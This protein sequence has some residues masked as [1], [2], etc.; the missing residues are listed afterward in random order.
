MKR[1]VVW[2]LK[3]NLFLLIVIVFMLFFYNSSKNLPAD[4]VS[5]PNIIMM[6]MIVLVIWNLAGAIFEYKDFLKENPVPEKVPGPRGVDLLK[7]KVS[8][9]IKGPDKKIDRTNVLLYVVTLLYGII[10]P[11]IGFGIM[12][13]AYLI[14]AAFLLGAKK[15]IGF[16]V[17]VV[18]VFGSIYGVFAVWLGVP[19]PKGLLF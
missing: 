4:A 19:F 6:C 9:F 11:F 18:A 16:V 2:F 12:S 3:N 1:F 14:G 5:Y 17:F 15:S 8:N 10:M 7:A 13:I